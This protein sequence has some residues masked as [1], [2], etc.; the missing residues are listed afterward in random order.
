[1]V[2]PTVTEFFQNATDTRRGR[3]AAIV[4]Y[5]LA[6]HWLLDQPGIDPSRHNGDKLAQLHS[7]LIGECEAFGIIRDIADASKHAEL[8]V[9]AK[10]PRRLSSATQV[11][12][13]PGIFE[14]PF[15]TAVFNEASIV[16]YTLDDR[17]SRPL[18]GAIRA[19]MDMWEQKLA[20][21]A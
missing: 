13:S 2:R 18:V 20:T 6:D 7:L 4:L 19:V 3:L 12:R 9:Q 1:M 17:T 15:G 10:N 5:H 8:F 14:A 21:A 11:T 16:M